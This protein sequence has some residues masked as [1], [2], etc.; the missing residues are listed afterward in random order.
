VIPTLHDTLVQISAHPTWAY[1]T[2]FAIA[3]LEA[4]PVAGSFIPGST[5]ILALSAAIATGGLSLPAMLASA[6]AGALLGD[7]AAYWA[8]HRE[9]RQILSSWPLSSYPNVVARSESF[10]KRHGALA[11]FFARFVAP[12]RAFVPVTAGALGMPPTRFFPVNV[13]AILLW[14]PLHILPGFMAASALQRWGVAGDHHWLSLIAIATVAIVVAWTLWQHVRRHDH[15][16]A[17]TA[18]SSGE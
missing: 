11:V 6:I 8:G 1:A 3:L 16:P 15:L 18:Q 13:V 14:A 10:F 12:V 2:V 7:G 5:I 9:K 17:K 4:V